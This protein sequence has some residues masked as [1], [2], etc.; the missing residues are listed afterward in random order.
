V[1][2]FFNAGSDIVRWELTVTHD[3]ACRIVIHH[4]NGTTVQH[5]NTVAAALLRVKQLEDLLVVGG[6]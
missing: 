3:R 6:A 5:F 4:T 1:L 2:S